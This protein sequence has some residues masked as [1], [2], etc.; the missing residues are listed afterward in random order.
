MKR[1]TQVVRKRCPRDG[2]KGTDQIDFHMVE[3]CVWGIKGSN[4][5][6]VVAMHLGGLAWD[7]APRPLANILLQVIPSETFHDEAN[8]GFCAWTGEATYGV[9]DL[10]SEGSRSNRSG[11]A[12]RLITDDLDIVTKGSCCEVGTS[13]R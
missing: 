9:E 7:A 2:E 3:A 13:V 5:C 12:R 4:I 11:N 1:F 6:F 8:G 10:P